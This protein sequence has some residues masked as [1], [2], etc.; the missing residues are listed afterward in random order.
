MD[1]VAVTHRQALE[2]LEAPEQAEA[3]AGIALGV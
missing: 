3:C 1:F 2:Y